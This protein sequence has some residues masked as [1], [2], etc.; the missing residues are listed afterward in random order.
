MKFSVIMPVKNGAE[1]MTK[2]LNSIGE[3]TFK[4]YELIVVCDDCSDNTKEI[5]ESYGAKVIE[6][7]L[8]SPGLAKNLALDIAQGEYILFINDDDWYT[9]SRAFEF[10]N[11]QLIGCNADILCYGFIMGD[12]GYKRPMDNNGSLYPGDTLKAWKRSAIGDTRFMHDHVYHDY[13]F[14]KAMLRKD[15]NVMLYDPAIYYHD[16]MRPGSITEVHSRQEA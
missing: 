11:T 14:L 9:H 8:K 2:A 16:Y 1:R 13:L 7:R 12:F 6:C 3:Q 10:L 5:A 15:L 4:D